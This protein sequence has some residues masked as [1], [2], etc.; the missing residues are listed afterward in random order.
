[1]QL[2]VI[3]DININSLDYESNIIVKSFFN[4]LFL[5]LKIYFV[6]AIGNHADVAYSEFS[7]FFCRGIRYSFSRNPEKS[8]KK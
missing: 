3:C 5:H 4:Y 6:A 8:R 7:E 1:M 2:F